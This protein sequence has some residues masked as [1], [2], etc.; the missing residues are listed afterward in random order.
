MKKMMFIFRG[1]VKA[2]FVLALMFGAQS[3]SAQSIG[4]QTQAV[5]TPATPGGLSVSNATF[6]SSVEAVENLTTQAQLLTGVTYNND[7]QENTSLLRKDYYKTLAN[8]I[9][10]GASPE[11]A[12]MGSVAYLNDVF[13]Q[14]QGFINTTMN[15]VFADALALIAD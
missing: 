12:L 9:Q 2:S 1:L 8:T 7:V 14:K 10:G 15:Q 3:M 5:S 6:L 13:V 11:E 4:T